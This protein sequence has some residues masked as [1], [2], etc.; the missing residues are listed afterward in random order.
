MLAGLSYDEILSLIVGAGFKP[1]HASKVCSALYRS[2]CET[3]SGIEGI[4]KAL[5][6]YL[7]EN[8]DFGV[9]LP[10]RTELSADGSEK[11]IYRN[12]AGQLFESVFI[13]EGR[14]KTLCISC[15]SGCRYG[16][17]VC[18]TGRYGF[19]GNLTASDMINQVIGNPHSG[20]ITH[21]VFMGMG[22]PMDNLSEV[23]KA[24]EI[25]T[26]EWGVAL[27]RKNITVST[28]GL[29][30]QTYSFL[31]QTECNLA[32]SLYS[33][34]SEE[35]I[36]FV[37]AEAFHPFEDL[38]GYI[39]KFPLQK[40]RRVSIAYVMIKGVN[41]SDKHLEA[42]VKILKN[43]GI[44]INLLPFHS[45]PETELSPSPVSQLEYFKHK[46]ITSGVSASVRKSRG[47]DISGACGL[48]AS[49]F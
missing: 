25:L 8:H 41:D 9:Y 28:V 46:L 33:P 31:Q 7:V 23:L 6:N 47:T 14:R 38:V 32:I 49:G 26:A 13:P 2:K 35:R 42:L 34:F 15:Q 1:V 20:N 39:T 10:L 40:K 44:R 3:A 27:S 12:G 4:P 48:L 30:P 21:V 43:T 11:Y 29:I 16:C 18:A 37:P 17:L 45:I 24:I 19:F 22:E 36:S 5:R